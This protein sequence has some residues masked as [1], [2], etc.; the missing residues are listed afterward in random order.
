MPSRLFTGLVGNEE[1]PVGQSFDD[2]EGFQ[3]LLGLQKPVKMGIHGETGVLPL[4]DPG[5][6][7]EGTHI[8]KPDGGE[9]FL[10]PEEGEPG[11]AEFL[12][13]HGKM[14]LREGRGQIAAE[15]ANQC[16]VVVRSHLLGDEQAAGL[17]NP[18][19]LIRMEITVAVDDQIKAAILEGQGTTAAAGAEIDAQ[20]QERFGAEGN[21]GRI[22]FH[23]GG[24]A[25]G[26][27]QAQQKFAAAGIDIQKLHLRMELLQDRRPVIPGQTLFRGIAAF[28][29]GKIPAFYVGNGLF[30]LPKFA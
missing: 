28:N 3:K 18:E 15:Q 7:D 13:H 14:L 5:E 20:G 6:P 22:I 10:A 2:T 17:Q 1:E 9:S 4:D 11:P 23:G 24:I 12:L 16:P 26:M 29:M 30:G 25:V 8:I 19:D 27:V 21:I